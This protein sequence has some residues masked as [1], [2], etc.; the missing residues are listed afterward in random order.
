MSSQHLAV[1]HPQVSRRQKGT[2]AKSGEEDWVKAMH[3]A[4]WEGGKRNEPLQFAFW[5]LAQP[6]SCYIFTTAWYQRYYPHFIEVKT[7]AQGGFHLP[8]MTQS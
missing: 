2:S 7:E 4:V 3:V 1:R 8:K 5:E 6:L